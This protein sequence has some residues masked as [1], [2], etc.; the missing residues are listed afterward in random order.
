MKVNFCQKLKTIYGGVIKDQDG[1][2]LDLKMLVGRALLQDW[3]GEKLTGEEKFKRYELAK[4][5]Q[6]CTGEIEVSV[7]QV[8]LIRDLV[9]NY[10]PAVVGP[11]YEILN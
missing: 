11:V 4:A 8:K 6:N 5:V 1:E 3:P 10:G 7:D 9:A 2:E